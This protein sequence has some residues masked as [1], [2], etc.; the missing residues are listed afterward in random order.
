MSVVIACCSVV[1]GLFLFLVIFL[2]ICAHLG[3]HFYLVLL[4]ICGRFTSLSKACCG[5]CF[6]CICASFSLSEPLSGCF[7]SVCDTFM[8]IF[9]WPGHLLSL[10]GW[11]APF[12]NHFLA[13]YSLFFNLFVLNLHQFFCIMLVSY[14]V[15]FHLI[16]LTSVSLF[17]FQMFSIS[18]C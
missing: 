10:C 5:S 6:Q 16:V 17:L 1:V 4:Y 8:F 15:V 3:L 14:A 2:P 13:L 11:L 9:H 7:G 18:F 12:S